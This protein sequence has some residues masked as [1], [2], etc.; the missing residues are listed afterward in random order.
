MDFSDN[1]CK[2]YEVKIQ[3]I[4]T[5]VLIPPKDD[6]EEVLLESI[7][8][9]PENSIVAIASKIVSIGEGNCIPLE[10]V[11]DKD[12]L[13]KSESEKYLDRENTPGKYLL[14]TITNNL[15]IGTAGIDES[16]ANDHYILWPKNPS[17]SA[18]RLC[19]FLRKE[20]NVKNLGVVITDSHSIPMRRGIVGFSLSYWGFKPLHDYRGTQDLFGRDMKVSQTNF[21]DSLASAAVLN[22]GEGA[23]QTPLVLISQIEGLNY[24]NEDYIPVGE[25]SSFEVPLEEDLY[26]PFL[27]SVPWKDGGKAKR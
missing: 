17:A 18:K 11:D 27:T 14:H 16:N 12:A 19:Q 24:L 25:Y 23:E 2:N 5:R 26:K 1:F 8:E 21:P 20:F 15:L 9:I 10:E 7:K 4:R 22:M 13:I 6:L 3:A